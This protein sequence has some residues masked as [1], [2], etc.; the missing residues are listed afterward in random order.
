[1]AIL[2]LMLGVMLTPAPSI[3]LDS[4]DIPNRFRG[5]VVVARPKK[6]RDK[7]IALTFDDGPDPSVTPQILATLQKYDAKATFYLLGA[8]VKLFPK[9]VAQVA[10][11]G[12]AIGQHSYSHPSKADSAKAR[13]EFS[14]V[15][16]LIKE[17]IGYTPIM[18]RPP[19]GVTKNEMTPLAISRKDVVVIW[20]ASS[21]DTATKSAE[22]VYKNVAFTPNPGEIVLLHDGYGK[23][24]TAE[25]LPKILAT[26]KK[27]GFKF[28][29]VPDLL[30]RYDKYLTA[31]PDRAATRSWGL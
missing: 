21:A 17:V 6:F 26:L 8:N 15:N 3:R 16:S 13:K 28:V 5:K 24:W 9:V 29:T 25:A 30:R 23:T 4:L 1:M 2:P 12:H 19:Y 27:K 22:K 14:S 18:F 10:A 31:Y 11:A 20:T 7:V